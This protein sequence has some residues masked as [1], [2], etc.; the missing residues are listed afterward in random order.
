MKM[1]MVDIDVR[2]SSY[3]KEELA[4]AADQQLW[5]IGIIMLLKSYSTIYRESFAN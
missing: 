1:G 5:V 2:V 3:L 4:W